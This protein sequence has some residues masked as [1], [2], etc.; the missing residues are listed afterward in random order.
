MQ[1]RASRIP[2]LFGAHAMA[3][4]PWVLIVPECINDQALIAHERVHLLE[5]ELAGLVRWWWRY[6]TSPGFRMAAEVRAYRAQIAA[7][8]ITPQQAAS[9]IERLY[10]LGISYD[11]ALLALVGR[12]QDERI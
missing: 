7:G 4:H 3:V 10:Y 5:Q 11:T 12:P 6:L 9:H 2:R 1:V 8:G